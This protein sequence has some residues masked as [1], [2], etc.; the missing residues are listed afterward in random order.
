[1]A[2]KIKRKKKK[3]IKKAVKNVRKT[4]K[5]SI[6]KEMQTKSYHKKTLGESGVGV[7]RS[8]SLSGGWEEEHFDDSVK[9]M[10]PMTFWIGNKG[11]RIARDGHTYEILRGENN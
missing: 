5:Q 1:M 8:P 2:V 11:Y 4:R 7:G 10:V 6:L 3:V 9:K